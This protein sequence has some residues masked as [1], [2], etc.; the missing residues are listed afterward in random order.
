MTATSAPSTARDRRRDERG[1]WVRHRGLG[2]RHRPR[3]PR[4]AGH[5][6]EAVLLRAEPVRFRA[7]HQHRPGVPRPARL[8][9]RA[10]PGGGGAGH[11]RRPGA[12]LR[13]PP[14]RV[15]PEE[16]LLPG[17]AEGLPDLPVRPAAQRRR[18]AG[19]ARRHPRRRH[20][21]P[22]GGGHRQVHP[23]GRRRAHPR[24]RVLPRGLQPGRRPAARDRL[25]SPTCARPTTPVPTSRSC[26]PSSSPS[27]RPTA[28][29]R[30]GRCGSTPTSRCA[31]R[32]SPR[33]PLRDQERQLAALAG[34]GHRLRGHPPDRADHLGRAGAPA[35]PPLGRGVGAHPARPGQGEL[36][37]LPLLPRARPGTGRAGPGLGRA[38]CAPALPMLPA[39][40]R[41][42]PGRQSPASRGS[43]P[44]S[45]SPCSAASTSWR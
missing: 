5:A 21:G 8:T 15:R 23:P 22:P 34:P 9:A 45:P 42:P 25:A 38:S 12:A 1:R 19:A 30:R 29:S 14:V 41:R 33:H 32:A 4:R 28:S 18:L 43:T 17:H 3:G 24:R 39:E 10:Q 11:P 13:D 40:R 2:D 35:D 20:P 36:R 31:D 37:R 26:A 16:L 44:P 27:A 7:Q 6:H